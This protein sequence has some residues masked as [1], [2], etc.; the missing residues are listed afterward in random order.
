MLLF[1]EGAFDSFGHL[2]LAGT[3]LVIRMPFRKRATAGEEAARFSRCRF[4]AIEDLRGH[5]FDDRW[6]GKTLF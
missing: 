6:S 4:M 2:N 1:F 5:Y 3:E